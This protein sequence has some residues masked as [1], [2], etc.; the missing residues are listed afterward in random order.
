MFS[1][2]HIDTGLLLTIFSI[3]GSVA[4]FIR[5]LGVRLRSLDNLLDDW[6]GEPPRPGVPGRPGVMKRLGD[7]EDKVNCRSTHGD[8][9]IDEHTRLLNEI[10]IKLDKEA[11]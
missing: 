6:N 2:A 9:V 5:W 10:I 8:A 3:I 7:I 4:A 11:K 1:D